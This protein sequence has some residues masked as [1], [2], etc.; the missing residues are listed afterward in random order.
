MEILFPVHLKNPFEISGH[1]FKV[2][3]FIIVLCFS[4]IILSHTVA[5]I[6]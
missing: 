6:E 5:G 1:E 2:R 4:L 3:P